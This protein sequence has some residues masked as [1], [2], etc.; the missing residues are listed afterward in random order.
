[1]G[2]FP[3][4]RGRR[5]PSHRDI[6]GGLCRAVGA[7]KEAVMAKPPVKKTSTKASPK[8]A[9]RRGKIA[10]PRITADDLELPDGVAAN[11]KGGK[12]RKPI[13]LPPLVPIPK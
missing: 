13:K 8:Q 5:D 10:L 4:F 7:R 1:L 11:V 9:G 12:K 3:V 2:A 6:L